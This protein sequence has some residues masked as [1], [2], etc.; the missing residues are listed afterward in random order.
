V[1]SLVFKSFTESSFCFKIICHRKL[2]AST[3]QLILGGV[4][5]LRL[6]E[7]VVLL[8]CR[9]LALARGWKPPDSDCSIIPKIQ[10]LSYDNGLQGGP[11]RKILATKYPVVLLLLAGFYVAAIYTIRLS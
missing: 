8:S 1:L 5:Y 3:V 9:P 11:G 6:V 7:P 2:L 4:C 10:F